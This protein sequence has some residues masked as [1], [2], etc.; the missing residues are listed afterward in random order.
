MRKKLNL[1]YRKKRLK[2]ENSK[3]L[4]DYKELKKSCD[5]QIK[6]AVRGNESQIAKNEK[7]DPKM[8]KNE[9]KKDD[10]RSVKG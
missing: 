4:E 1:W 2:Q 8:V 5:N 3:L 10:K 9:F 6:S 7:I